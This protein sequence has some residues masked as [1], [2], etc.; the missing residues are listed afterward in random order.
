MCL[1][2]FLFDDNWTLRTVSRWK[3]QEWKEASK[4]TKI[5][6]QGVVPVDLVTFISIVGVIFFY[7][8]N[9][10]NLIQILIIIESN[11]SN[12]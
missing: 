3:V 6:V 2:R 4:S 11:S 1:S 12:A 7:I 5:T 8:I 9:A 10:R